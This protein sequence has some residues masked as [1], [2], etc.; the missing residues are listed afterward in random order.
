MAGVLVA[1]HAVA[2]DESTKGP[3]PPFVLRDLQNPE[4][5]IAFTNTPTAAIKFGGYPSGTIPGMEYRRTQTAPTNVLLG[6]S[7]AYRD[8][9]GELRPVFLTLTQPHTLS[10]STGIVTCS[11]IETFQLNTTLGMQV[12]DDGTLTV[13]LFDAVATTN[14]NVSAG[15]TTGGSTPMTFYSDKQKT[16]AS[17]GRQVSNVLKVNA[18]VWHPF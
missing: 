9:A 18:S 7:F 2:Q 6:V 8:A 14:N 3:Q 5:T 4:V 17:Y 13:A 11:A 12:R 15:A 10:N 1:V 16:S